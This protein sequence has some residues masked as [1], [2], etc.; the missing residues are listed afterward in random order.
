MPQF[1]TSTPRITRKFSDIEFSV[2]APFPE[3]HTL[4]ANEAKFLNSTLASVVG[5][6]YSGD[7][8]RAKEAGKD[9]SIW[10]HQ[11]LFEAKFA[12]YELG[13]SNRGDGTG[14]AASPLDRT[15][16]FLA[17]EDVK[18]RL[19]A[20]GFKVGVIQRTKNADGVSKFAELV[21]K[22]IEDNHERFAAQAQAMLDAQPDVAS[23]DDDLLAGLD[24]E[25]T[26]TAEAA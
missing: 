7:I 19:I 25:T 5:N 13:V 24:A 9:V 8:R 18:A 12:D 26:P 23:E 14:T 17:S 22:N 2:P 11:A 16:A 1:D 15:I 21:A 10:D 3:G 4:S 20:K 6:A